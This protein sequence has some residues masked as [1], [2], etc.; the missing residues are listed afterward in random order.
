MYRCAFKKWFGS[1][2]PDVS[3]PQ[4][5]NRWEMSTPNQNTNLM[6]VSRTTTILIMKTKTRRAWDGAKQNGEQM[7]EKPGIQ[8]LTIKRNKSKETRKTGN[9]TGEWLKES[10][11]TN[12]AETGTRRSKVHKWEEKVHTH[13]AIKTHNTM[14]IEAQSWHCQSDGII[15]KRK[16]QP[17]LALCNTTPPDAITGR[18]QYHSEGETEAQQVGVNHTQT[19]DEGWRHQH[20]LHNQQ[21]TSGNGKR[22]WG[23]SIGCEPDQTLISNWNDQLT[24][25]R[26]EVLLRQDS[27]E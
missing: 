23:S 18:M 22:S 17:S 3:Y 27:L 16:R 7:P 19:A 13:F 2:V 8:K 4:I 9:E 5:H 6:H 25:E 14:G 15:T 21:H 1:T 10:V 20:T 12:G 11:C 24:D 26:G